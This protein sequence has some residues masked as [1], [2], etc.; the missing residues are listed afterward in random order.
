M[1]QKTIKEWLLELPKEERELI[2]FDTL[3]DYCDTEE[4][5]SLSDALTAAFIWE[6]TKE[7]HD[8]WQ[9]IRNREF[10]NKKNKDNGKV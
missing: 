7:G 8:F 1:K 3:H 4:A 6:N 5:H 10:D 9:N 2:D